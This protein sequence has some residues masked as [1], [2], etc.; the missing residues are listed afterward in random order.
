MNPYKNQD[1]RKFLESIPAEEIAERNQE[2]LKINEAM[3]E[4]FI[5]GMKQGLCFLV[6][7]S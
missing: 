6:N 7:G 5:D 4:E 2:Q 1:L 3:Y